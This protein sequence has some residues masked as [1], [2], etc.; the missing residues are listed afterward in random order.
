[1]YKTNHP[2]TIKF[3]KKKKKE[4]RDTWAI[5]TKNMKIKKIE[6]LDLKSKMRYLVKKFFLKMR[7]L[8]KNQK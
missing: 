2:S 3:K 8:G 1:M 4:K 6:I 7:Y 5:L